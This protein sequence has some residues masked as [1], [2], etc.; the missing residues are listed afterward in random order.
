MN[1]KLKEELKSLRAE[2]GTPAFDKRLEEM[3]GVYTSAEDKALISESVMLMLDDIGNGL[4]ELNEELTTLEAVK[5][6]SSMISF[7][8]IAETYFKKSKSWFSQRLNGNTVHGRKCGFND[9]ELHT[10]R[11]A[12]QD[13]SKK[14]G[15]LS[16]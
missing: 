8:Y 2:L 10:L 6:I 11:L 16:I 1:M 13:I 15:A 9:D 5:S 3:N 4:D 12:L 7:K 14:I